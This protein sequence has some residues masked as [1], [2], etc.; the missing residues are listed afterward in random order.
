M[1]DCASVNFSVIM[2]AGTELNILQKSGNME[3]SFAS[4]ST[5]KIMKLIVTI[6][7]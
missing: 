1:N 5:M 7:K 4:F 3:Y 6:I 2:F